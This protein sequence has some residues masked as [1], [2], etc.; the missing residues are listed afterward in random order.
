M[1]LRVCMISDHGDPL[2]TLGDTQS[3]GQNQYVY[4][5]SLHLDRLGHQVD[6]YTHWSREDAP[7]VEAFGDRARVIRVAAGKRGHLP[8]DDLYERLDLFYHELSAKIA[9][10]GPYDL[11]HA[12]YWMSGTL[13]RVLRRE[14]NYPLIYTPHSL[15]M[16][17][18]L[19]TGSWDWERLWKER[20][21]LVEADHVVVTTETE[22][23]HA[24]EFCG[25]TATAPISVIPA[26]VGEHFIADPKAESETDDTAARDCGVPVDPNGHR[27]PYV[28]YVGRLAMEKGLGVLLDAYSMWVARNP[29]VPDLWIAGGDREGREWRRWTA[30]HAALGE[31][32]TTIPDRVHYLG[33]VANEKLPQL[34]R[35]AEMV[36]VPSWYE[37][38]GLVAAEAM[39]AGGVVIASG[40]GG[41]RH[42]VQDGV[43]G[44]LVPP[45]DSGALVKA[46]DEMWVSPS[47]RNAFRRK[48]TRDARRRFFW[49][50]IAPQVVE[51]YL[52]Y[53]QQ[54]VVLP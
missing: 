28:L 54:P 19:R 9:T 43:T 24:K 33:P 25:K 40:V 23:E 50:N 5:L 21:I 27:R 14:L 17:K 48:G 41:L 36:V 34:Y 44:R 8:K 49:P 26:G 46:M 30:S 10:C 12:H 53:V 45:R 32:L 7:E 52:G 39:A 38:F 3:G 42:I 47:L 2:A 22:R 16:V 11:V 4:Q 13:G 29:D 1:G 6:V 31:L 20:S 15:G 35:G 18:G 37:S 51:I